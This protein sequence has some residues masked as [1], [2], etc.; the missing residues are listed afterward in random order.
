MVSVLGS[1]YNIIFLKLILPSENS[2]C[3][4]TSEELLVLIG[5]IIQHC[6]E[7]YFKIQRFFKLEFCF[8]NDNATKVTI[9]MVGRAGDKFNVVFNNR[10]AGRP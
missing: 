7:L 9:V 8:R 5:T 2:L 6:F 4:Y 10:T 1:S 3:F